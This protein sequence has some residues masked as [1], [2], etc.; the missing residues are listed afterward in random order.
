MSKRLASF[1]GPSTPSSSP[2]KHKPSVPPSP[3]RAV[4]TTYHRKIR[5]LLQEVRSILRIWDELVKIDG[6]RLI[7]TLTDTRTDLR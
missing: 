7:T 3:S 5:T 2:V 4:E 1:Q 6:L